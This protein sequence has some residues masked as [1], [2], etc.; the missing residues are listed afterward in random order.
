[1]LNYFSLES[2]QFGP[3][4]LHYYKLGGEG[5]LNFPIP[6]ASPKKFYK[7]DHWPLFQLQLQLLFGNINRRECFAV[8][9][10]S[11]GWIRSLDLFLDQQDLCVRAVSQRLLDEL[12]AGVEVGEA[13]FQLVTLF[14]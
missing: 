14:G 2:D 5:E 1:M 7:I 9:L 11:N 10:I 6:L 4:F 3:I 12:A 8:S 13:A